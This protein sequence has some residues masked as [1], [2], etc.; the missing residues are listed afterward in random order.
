MGTLDEDFLEEKYEKAMSDWSKDKTKWAK[1]PASTRPS[2]AP[3]EPR[4]DPQEFACYCYKMHCALMDNGNGCFLCERAQEKGESYQEEDDD[5]HGRCSCP[6]CSC[7]CMQLFKEV[8]R[9]K[10]IQTMKIEKR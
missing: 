5:G 4:K 7:Q 2:K 10:I 1:Q 3:R 9:Q 8:E 6:V